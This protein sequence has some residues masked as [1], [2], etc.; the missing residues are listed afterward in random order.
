MVQEAGPDE[1]RAG[2]V[3]QV[4]WFLGTSGCRGWWTASLAPVSSGIRPARRGV[5]RLRLLTGRFR[6]GGGAVGG[7]GCGQVEEEEGVVVGVPGSAV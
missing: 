4:R 5:P 2:R 7:A 3:R 6:G 1:E